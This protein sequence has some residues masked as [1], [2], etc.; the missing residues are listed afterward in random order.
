MQPSDTLIMELTERIADAKTKFM[1]AREQILVLDQQIRDLE[2]RYKRAVHSKKNAFRY[3]LRLKLSVTT[4][5][6]MMYHH[7]ASIKADEIRQIQR[8]SAG[9]SVEEPEEGGSGD[10]TSPSVGEADS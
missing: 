9:E 6:K 10:S 8:Q 3:N 4:G 7:Y 2:T 5:V 1:K